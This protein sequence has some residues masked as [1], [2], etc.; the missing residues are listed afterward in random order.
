MSIDLVRKSK[1]LPVGF[2]ILPRVGLRAAGVRKLFQS[3]CFFSMS[4]NILSRIGFSSLMN[5][6]KRRFHFLF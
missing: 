4:G 3:H 6:I 5:S 1:F 2:Q